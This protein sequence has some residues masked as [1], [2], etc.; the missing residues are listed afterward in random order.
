MSDGISRSRKSIHLSNSGVH[1]LE[2]GNYHNLDDR[3]DT[4]V[5]KHNKVWL[6]EFPSNYNPTQRG[7]LPRSQLSDS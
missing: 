3:Q 1:N 2:L 4:T 7:D 6:P 5:P